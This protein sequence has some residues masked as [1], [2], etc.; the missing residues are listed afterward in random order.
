MY[1]ILLL[2]AKPASK[3]IRLNSYTE[4]IKSGSSASI[5]Q[6]IL[7]YLLKN[8][9]QSY[10]ARELTKALELI[11][12]SSITYPLLALVKQEKIEV[13][14]KRYDSFTNRE[15]GTYQISQDV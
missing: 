4:F 13:A 7:T 12:R 8:P 10:T 11:G 9:E 6:K 1:C 15:V 3:K 14:A 5:R 2:S